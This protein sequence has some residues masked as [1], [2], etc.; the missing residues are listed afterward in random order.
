MNKTKLSKEKKTK[1]KKPPIILKNYYKENCIEAGIDEVGRGC[2]S[3][4]VVA[5]AVVFAEASTF[6]LIFGGVGGV[7]SLTAEFF[8]AMRRQAPFHL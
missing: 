7:E 2:L 6:F 5:A 8:L 4:P 1:L 3:G